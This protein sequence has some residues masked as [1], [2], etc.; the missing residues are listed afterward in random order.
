MASSN[1]RISSNVNLNDYFIYCP[2]LCEKEGQENRKILYYYPSDVDIDR[3]IRTV[4]YCEGLVKFTETFGFDDPCDSVHFQKTRLLFYKIENDIC[5]AMSLHIPVVERKKDDKF[6]TEYYDENINDRIML[7][8]LKMSYRYFV[9][10]HGT[11]STTIQHGG[12]EELRVVLKQHFDKF[13][14]HHVLSMIRDATLDTSYIGIQFLPVE[15]KLYLKLQSILRRLELRFSSLK[16]TLFL[17]KDQLIWSGLSQEDTSLVYSF[18]RL[19]Y[20]PHVKVLL[21]SSTTQYLTIDTNANPADELIISATPTSQ[22]YQAFFLGNP[23]MPYRVLV[24]NINLITIFSF[25]HDDGDSTNI[26]DMNTQIVDAL[27]KDLDTMLPHFEEHLK[28][29]YPS[30]DNTVRTVY[31]NKINMAY[32][33]TV[34]WTR[35]PVNSMAGIMNTLAED[36][37]WFH[38]SGEIMVKRENDPW[39]ISKRSD[40]RE[41]LFVVN[42]KNANLKEISEKKS[43]KMNGSSAVNGPPAE[44]LIGKFQVINLDKLPVN[45]VVNHDD[46]SLPVSAIP[47]ES[48]NPSR[49]Q[50]IRVDRNFGRG[51]WK[52]ND[53]EPPENLV[54][55][56]IPPVNTIENETISIANN[57]TFANLP[58]TTATTTTTI[59][60]VPVAVVPTVV[61]ADTN[62]GSSASAAAAA[63]AV[64][65]ATAFQQQ[66]MALKNAP[67]LVPAANVPPPPGLLHAYQTA[68]LPNQP[69]LLPNHPQFGYYPFYPTPYAPYPASWAAA[70]A[71]LAASNPYLQPP[72]LPPPTATASITD[73]IRL[74][75]AASDINAENTVMSSANFTNPTADQLQNAQLAAAAAAAPF[76]YAAHHSH[77]PYMPQISSTTSPYATIPS[78]HPQ[79]TLPTIVPR[80]Q[81][82]P[83]FAPSQMIS[84]TAADLQSSYQ[85]PIFALPRYDTNQT[86]TQQS[87]TTRTK[88]L[89]TTLVNGFTNEP[90]YT[91]QVA[92]LISSS[93]LITTSDSMAPSLISPI[94]TT[95]FSDILTYT[96]GGSPLNLTQKVAATDLLNNNNSQNTEITNEILKELT[97]PTK[98]NNTTDIDSKISAAMD[99][100]KMHLLSAVR[101]EVTELRQQIRTLN[102][103]VS[104]AEHENAFLRQ[105]VPSEI[106][107]QYIPTV[108]GITSSDESTNPTAT[109]S[110]SS[111]CLSSSSQPALINSLSSNPASL[112]QQPTPLPIN[113]QLPITTTSIAPT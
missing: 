95:T 100:V 33:S 54:A 61:P 2:S 83:I 101:D 90:S 84:S 47:D 60:N 79:P 82:M 102:D 97:T 15:K 58:T 92:D 34:D 88:P 111:I 13:I 40:M 70:A 51:R 42:Q 52:V 71:A 62:V 10:Q 96:A 8:I 57:S 35:E 30:A 9:L 39:I 25:F 46:T 1:E 36:M 26:E 37:Q 113:L 22:I 103:I 73:P 107:A 63:A 14:Q 20:W 110:L 77:A 16:E 21:N 80:N 81:P 89:G 49:F 75:D 32:S 59:P 24:V 104:N 64:A 109:T 31:Y 11:M 56:I 72:T 48:G 27:K 19:Y 76:L 29:K 67:T 66:Q 38:P 4:G 7:P 55:A 12:V 53:Y 45:T 3:Q 41:L 105:Y 112:A 78:Y 50:M 68:T 28:K 18:F 69:Y 99:L 85:T 74:S 65:V 43:S 44:Q 87:S 93:P 108:I 98:Q 94:K 86:N 91:T 23:P 5:I 17:Y 6:V 106:C